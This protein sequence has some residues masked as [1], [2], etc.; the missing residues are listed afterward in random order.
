MQKELLK[1]S[2]VYVAGSMIVQVLGFIGLVFLMRYLP[3]PEYGKYIYIIEF[4]SIFAFFADGG[5]TQHII[6][7]SSQ[8]PNKIQNIYS[9]AQSA[10]ILIS[11][12]MLLLIALFSYTTNSTT[13]F[14][15][16]IVFGLSVVISS[17]FAPILAIIIA[18]DRKD[19]IFYKDI[20]LSALKLLFMLLGIYYK[21]PLQYFIFLGFINCIVLSLL[22]IYTKLKKEFS[23]LF[24]IKIDFSSSF[25]FI[26]QGLLF[27]ILMAANVIYNKIDIVMLEKMLGSTEVGY[28]SGAT[29]FIYPFMF[30]SGAFMTAIFPSLAKYSQQK[31]K[32]N[33]IQYIALYYLGGIGILLSSLLF[34]SSDIIFKFFFELKYDQSIPTFKV[35]VWYLA[36]VFIYGSISNNL[37][38]IGKVKFL[39]LLNLIMILINIALN[40]FLIPKYGALG[41]AIATIA[42]EILILIAAGIYWIYITKNRIKNDRLNQNS[43]DS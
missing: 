2:A 21:A 17:L 8:N 25:S 31:D 38:A 1:N 9:K 29:R 23:Y 20:A 36:I 6:K 32:F 12:I 27:T 26:K 24:E 7:E 15:L 39:V 10:Q 14:Y 28:Y 16:L 5:F 33:R 30:I 18:S 43:L 40:F 34:M 11:A 35:L 13:D 41:A 4:I 3:I 22:L 42:C 37:V 19:L